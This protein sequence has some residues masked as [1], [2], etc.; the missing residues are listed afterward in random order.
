MKM[1]STE[2]ELHWETQEN[3]ANKILKRGLMFLN[4][5]FI[6]FFKLLKYQ[7]KMFW[8]LI[9]Y[10]SIKKYPVYDFINLDK[11]NFKCLRRVYSL[12]LLRHLLGDS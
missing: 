10:C 4:K 9:I 6:Y 11:K 2:E 3:K 5:S 1:G 12:S 8:I 7:K